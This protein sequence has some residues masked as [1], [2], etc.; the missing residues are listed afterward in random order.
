MSTKRDINGNGS[1][2]SSCQYLQAQDEY[3]SQNQHVFGWQQ[4]RVASTRQKM[5]DMWHTGEVT[6]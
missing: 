6:R 5:Q 1:I 4:V 2:L 3:R